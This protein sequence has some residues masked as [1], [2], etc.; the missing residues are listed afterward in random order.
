[1]R[2]TFLVLYTLLTDA[3]YNF[4]RSSCSLH[5]N[6]KFGLENKK[7]NQI[8]SQ[9]STHNGIRTLLF[10]PSAVDPQWFQFNAD[11]DPAFYLIEYPDPGSQTNAD[12]C[13]PGPD[14]DPGQT[15]SQKKLNFARKIRIPLRVRIRIEDNQI[16]ADPCGPGS[17]FGSWS[18]LQVRKN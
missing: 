11:T 17:G 4:F 2:Y 8:K 7:I 16:N 1:M 18:D 3:P 14:S 6:V 12:P 13:G 9:A 15:Q 10:E 5:L